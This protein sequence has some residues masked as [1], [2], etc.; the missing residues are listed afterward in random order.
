M[1]YKLLVVLINVLVLPLLVAEAAECEGGEPGCFTR[2]VFNAWT[3]FIGDD[4]FDSQ[5]LWD[6][7]N[8]CSKRISNDE[9]NFWN[10][11]DNFYKGFLEY[12]IA[13]GA[14]DD[15]WNGDVFLDPT[16][17][18]LMSPSD[19]DRYSLL[20]SGVSNIT[21]FKPCSMVSDL[22]FGRSVMAF[23]EKTDWNLNEETA[24]AL[25]RSQTNTYHPGQF[26]HASGTKLG[27]LTDIE[28]VNQ[29][30]FVVHQGTLQR[31][32]FDPL[33]HNL[34]LDD[35][36]FNSTEA[37]YLSTLIFQNDPISEWYDNFGIFKT[38]E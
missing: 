1:F 37:A 36:P 30:A 24:L 31:L 19:E 2:E 4:K 21:I 8:A 25:I 38:T 27:N 29:F 16:P 23:C 17:T 10:T 32:P 22:S 3:N 12:G 15:P 34:G 18:P 13:G 14:V 33:L 35:V 11:V 7:M 26:Y 28:G 9:I 5:E 20:P 6:R